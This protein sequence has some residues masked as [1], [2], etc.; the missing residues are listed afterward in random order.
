MTLHSK[1][2]ASPLTNFVFDWVSSNPCAFRLERKLA[3]PAK[4]FVLE[5]LPVVDILLISLSTSTTLVRSRRL[6][7]EEAAAVAT[8]K[9]VDLFFVDKSSSSSS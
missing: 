6:G 8:V 5:L 7:D 4:F 2:D 1:H 3:S 9:V